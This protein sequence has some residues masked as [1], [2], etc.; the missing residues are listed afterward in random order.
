MVKVSVVD[1]RQVLWRRSRL[2]ADGALVGGFLPVYANFADQAELLALAPLPRE[3][4]G[5]AAPVL[6]LFWRPLNPSLEDWHIGIALAA[7]DGSRWQT[8]LR[9]ARWSREPPSVAEWPPGHYVRMDRHLDLPPGLPPGRYEVVLSL[10]DRSTAEPASVLD[11]A[12]NPIAPALNLGEITVLRP[13]EVADALMLGEPLGTGPARCGSLAL[14]GG[15]PDRAAA[16][17]GDELAVRMVWEATSGPQDDVSVSLTLLDPS[18]APIQSWSRAPAGGWWPVSSWQA[19][20]RWVGR[21]DVRLPGS[22]TTGT[23]TLKL[24]LPGCELAT[25]AID[26][27][28]PDRTWSLPED[29]VALEGEDTTLGGVLRLASTRGL[30]ADV[31]P[32]DVVDLVLAWEALAEITV[33]YRVFVHV[34]DDQGTIIAQNDGEPVGWTR[35]TTGWAIGEIVIDGRPLRI[36]G[37]ADAGVYEVRAGVYDATSRVRLATGSGEDALLLGELVLR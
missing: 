33:P 11:E 22:L 13:A 17:P 19:G 18:G 4:R 3:V 27:V 29:F 12:G 9:T 16:A 7:P 24:S 37:D 14:L 6:S 10:F 28:A 8:G 26:V 20:D 36:P 15:G 34:V 21:A 31:A 5:D 35:P 30:D 32:G 23:H 1:S 2:T 25:W